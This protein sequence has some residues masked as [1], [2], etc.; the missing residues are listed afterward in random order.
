LIGTAQRKRTH[1]TEAHFSTKRIT[2]PPGYA[3]LLLLLLL[4]VSRDLV[5]DEATAAA[6]GNGDFP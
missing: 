3:R 4:A 1:N 2:N 6:D 5:A